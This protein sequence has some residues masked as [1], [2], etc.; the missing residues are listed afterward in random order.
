MKACKP[1]ACALPAGG[2]FPKIGK[3]LPYTSLTLL[4]A[5]HV[6]RCSEEVMYSRL[7]N[8]ARV[9]QCCMWMTQPQTA[10]EGSGLPHKAANSQGTANCPRETEIALEDSKLRGGS[11]MAEEEAMLHV[12]DRPAKLMWLPHARQLHS[13]AICCCEQQYTPS[14]TNT[15]NNF[16]EGL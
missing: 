15:A 6:A 16:Q 4:E 13:E 14:C 11:N 7:V 3:D 5:Q 2:Q 10:P 8:E 9:Q 12:G 1:K